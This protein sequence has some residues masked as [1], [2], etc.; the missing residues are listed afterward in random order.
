MSLKA[1]NRADS[2][3]HTVCKTVGSVFMRLWG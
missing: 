3:Q 1:E 2:T